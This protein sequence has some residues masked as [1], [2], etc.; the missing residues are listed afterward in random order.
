[1]S[2]TKISCIMIGLGLSLFLLWLY[3]FGIKFICNDKY[4]RYEA[5]DQTKGLL[6]VSVFFS[7]VWIDTYLFH[8]KRSNN[9]NIRNRKGTD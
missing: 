1:M 2:I 8:G 5:F 9:L 7:C 4:G 6:F 3:V